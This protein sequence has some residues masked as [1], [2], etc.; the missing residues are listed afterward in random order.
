MIQEARHA[1][2][3][4]KEMNVKTYVDFYEAPS[5]EGI[6]ALAD[7]LSKDVHFIDPFNN[8]K[9]QDKVIA[10]LEKMF[11]DVQNPRF[12][13]LDVIWSG[14]I[15]FLR[16]DFFCHQKMIGD[17]SFR[18]MSELHFDAAGKISAHYDYWDSG[19]HFYAKLP[20]IGAL[21]RAIIKRAS[22]R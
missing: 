20:I 19:L 10:I 4:S 2:Q 18:G 11:V 9:G 5:P 6:A 7:T 21:I 17:W 8:V 15:C 3:S 12:D 22:I 13:I 14:K 16:W 1:D